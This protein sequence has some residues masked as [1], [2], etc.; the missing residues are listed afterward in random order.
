MSELQKL[1]KD[2]AY[3]KW[4]LSGQV[5]TIQGLRSSEIELVKQI[6]KLRKQL[7]D[8]F[9]TNSRVLGLKAKSRCFCGRAKEDHIDKCK[10]CRE[11][12]DSM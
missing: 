11:A 8:G 7:I 5:L 4:R 2:R 12:C 10:R 3:F 6:E 1:A 9:I